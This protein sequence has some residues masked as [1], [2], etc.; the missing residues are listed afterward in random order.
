MQ[1]SDPLYDYVRTV[2]V[3][4]MA[5]LYSNGQR[6]VHVGAL[7]R[8]LGVPESQAAEHDNERIDIDENFDEIVQELNIKHLVQSKIPAGAIIH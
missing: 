8:L 2:M 3:E 4:V 1:D 5:V 7:M 6:S